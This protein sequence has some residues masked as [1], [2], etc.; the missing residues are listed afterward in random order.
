MKIILKVTTVRSNTACLIQISVTVIIAIK[1]FPSQTQVT[2]I[3][4][5]G[6]YEI[7]KKFVRNCFNATKTILQS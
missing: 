6:T 2:Q 5:I 4:N 7:C 1:I 3:V